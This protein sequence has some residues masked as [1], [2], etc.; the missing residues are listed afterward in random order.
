MKKTLAILLSVLL[1]TVFLTSTV[2]AKENAKD[3]KV[4]KEKSSQEVVEKDKL[5]KEQKQDKDSDRER[6][7]KEEKDKERIGQEEKVN[8]G[9]AEK[10]E[11]EAK[12]EEISQQVGQQVKNYGQA[13]KL[14]E[15]IRVRGMNLKFDVPPV[16]KEGRTLIPVRAI[17]NG[18]G[19]KVDWNAEIK[20]VTI[21][22]DGK[23]IILKLDTNEVLVNGETVTID[24]PAQLISNRTFVPLRFVAQTLGE[25]VNYD[26][27]TGEIDI[28]DE[29]ENDEN[30]D[31]EADEEVDEDVADETD[32]E[33]VAEEDNQ[34][35]EDTNE[36]SEDK[37]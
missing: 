22:R 4:V 31:E 18:L 32:E 7:E 2:W 33:E 19:A 5:I 17:M 9:Q 21:M 11:R 35:E 27:A 26:E 36:D 23:E 10:A 34:N 37:K 16:I 14:E 30:V 6:I 1:C 25:K 12:L 8:R 29:E 28:G 20:T 3:T 24:C 15:R 13:K